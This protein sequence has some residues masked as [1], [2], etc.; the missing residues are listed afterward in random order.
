M[1]LW[2]SG[3]AV[4]SKISMHPNLYKYK[5]GQAHPK[6]AKKYQPPGFIYSNVYTNWN[7][8]KYGKVKNSILIAKVHDT[9]IY[10]PL[11]APIIN[12]PGDSIMQNIETQLLDIVK[13]DFNKKKSHEVTLDSTFRKDLG[14]DSLSLTELLIACDEK[15]N[16]NI[17][18]DQYPGVAEARSLRPL[19]EIIEQI[20]NQTELNK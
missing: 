4:M 2:T 13:A 1:P 16:I 12:I 14:L 9:Y 18:L 10:W 15:F 19:C 3:K 17:D 20:V 5:A 7:R 11:T 6:I 8:C